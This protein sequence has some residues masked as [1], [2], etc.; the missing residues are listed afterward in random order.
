MKSWSLLRRSRNEKD[1]NW[2]LLFIEERNAKRLIKQVK[3]SLTLYE[4][5]QHGFHDHSSSPVADFTVAKLLNCL[6][7]QQSSHVRPLELDGTI[8]NKSL[9]RSVYVEQFCHTYCRKTRNHSVFKKRRS[10][11]GLKYAAKNGIK[12]YFTIFQK[13][14]L[15]EK[16]K[17][18]M[19]ISGERPY[20]ALPWG[21]SEVI[22]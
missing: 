9:E 14:S 16:Q 4:T 3:G 13:L 21:Q 11:Y 7:C 22:W 6:L 15:Q 1:C 17:R 20:H 12:C 18:A 10:L 19:H 8:K 2:N 5:E